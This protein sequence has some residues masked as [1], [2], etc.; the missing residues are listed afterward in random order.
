MKLKKLAYPSSL[1]H[2]SVL[3]KHEVVR[4]TVL[5]NNLLKTS[6]LDLESYS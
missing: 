4:E 6:Q 3:S 1:P 2:F 5:P